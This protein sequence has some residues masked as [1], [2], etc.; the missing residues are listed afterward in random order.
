MS[1]VSP[2][3]M[4]QSGAAPLVL[5]VDAS[6]DDRRAVTAL[7]EEHLGARVATTESGREALDIISKLPLSLVLTEV[8]TPDMDG[9]ELVERIRAAR[10]ALPVILMPA[11]GSEDL[12]LRALRAGAAS[13]VPKRLLGE[14]LVST[15]EGVLSSARQERRRGRVQDCMTRLEYDFELESDPSIVSSFVALVQDQIVRLKV[16][17]EAE[18]MRLGI[19]LEEALLNGIYHG[20]LE[21]SS[22]LKQDG[23]NA[24]Q[25]TAAERRRLS[26]YRERRLRVT[27]RISRREATFVVRDEGPGFD[28][29]SLPD[30]TDP[31]NM[32]K[33]SGRG[34]LLIRTFMDD[35]R[36]NASGNE[37]TM[38]KRAARA[39]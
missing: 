14:I 24:F 32:L 6:P 22:D 19:A 28:V 36:H 1:T 33:A 7:L 38:V 25:Q 35:V 13:Y 26:P 21:I 34:L 12:A 30:P 15:A 23:S 11:A 27:V 39:S 2:E 4:S 37:I 17:T 3:Y 5:V 29:T 31:D 18:K 9:L 20:N 10:P 16:C 8:Q